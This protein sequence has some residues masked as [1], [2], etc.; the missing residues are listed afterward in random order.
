MSLTSHSNWRLSRR[1]VVPICLLALSLFLLT[2][3][4]A[5]ADAPAQTTPGSEPC[6][7]CHWSE[8]SAWQHSPHAQNNVTCEDCHGQYIEDHPTQ[9]E[10]TLTANASQ[11]QSCHIDTTQQWLRSMHASSGVNCINCH[12]AH[13]QTT[14]LASEK[15]CIA[16]HA[17]NF[18]HE[19]TAT[20][21]ST[22]G[23]N[24]VEC[25]A[26]T[27]PGATEQHH[28]H[29]FEAVSGQLCLNCHESQMHQ[30]ATVDGADGT[31]LLQLNALKKETEVMAD[32]LQQSEQKNS[33][34][35]VISVVTLGTGL[36]VGIML[37]LVF[38][39]VFNYLNQRR[40][41]AS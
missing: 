18:D 29:A 13:S 10:M 17:T 5:L 4:T 21:H 37:G 25:H 23:V 30:P 9:G 26:A 41:N 31:A 3:A 40:E 27:V 1:I 36:G 33:F 6:A 38:L 12:V 2:P 14:R 19:I 35:Q 22:A 32:Q 20:A 15:L 24:C 28:S 39:F 11:C 8:T 16:C 7:E 34:L